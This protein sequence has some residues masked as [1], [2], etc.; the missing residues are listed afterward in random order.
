MKRGTLQNKGDIFRRHT[1]DSVRLFLIVRYP[2][3]GEP[4][5]CLGDGQ[6]RRVLSLGDAWSLWANIEI[7][8]AAEVFGG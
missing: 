2:R 8:T 7:M 6:R 5:A 1:F 3:C 4:F